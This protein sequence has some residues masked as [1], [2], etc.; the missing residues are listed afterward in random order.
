MN[1]L[2]VE[3]HTVAQV[4]PPLPVEA[5]SEPDTF[6]SVVLRFTKYAILPRNLLSASS[7]QA[8]HIT[9]ERDIK[10]MILQ[11]VNP[12]QYHC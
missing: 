5:R 2:S 4:E 11:E 12:T 10:T 8:A 7:Q 6:R 3:K 1:Y 9:I